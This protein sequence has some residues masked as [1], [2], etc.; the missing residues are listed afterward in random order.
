MAKPPHQG[1]IL[2]ADDDATIRGNLALLLQSEGFRVLEAS[3]GL[4]AARAFNDPSVALVLLDL[5]MPGLSG[6]DLL[7]EH[8]DQLEEKPVIVITALGA[9][10]WPSKP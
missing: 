1:T 10:R 3:D 5:K 6:M 9:A 7:R 2:V 4:Q 8:Q